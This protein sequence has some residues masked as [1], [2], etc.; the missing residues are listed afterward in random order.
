ML[1]GLEDEGHHID[2][3]LLPFSLAQIKFTGEST[4]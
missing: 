3:I 1:F 2:W 4:S